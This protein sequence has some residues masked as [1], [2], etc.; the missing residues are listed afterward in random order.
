MCVVGVAS[1]GRDTL[2]HADVLKPDVVLVDVFLGAESGLE[3]AQRLVDQDRNGQATVI[4][5]S[6]HRRADLADL[7]TA[8]CPAAGFLPKSELSANAISRI[9]DSRTRS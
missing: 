8:R 9:V 2:L 5:I 6:T 3:L 7:I 1:T 4:L